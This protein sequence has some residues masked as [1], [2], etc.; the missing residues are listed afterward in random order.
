MC[1][2]SNDYTTYAK[3]ESVRLSILYCI[4]VQK[5]SESSVEMMDYNMVY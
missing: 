3:K 4:K 1:S 5:Q 2:T